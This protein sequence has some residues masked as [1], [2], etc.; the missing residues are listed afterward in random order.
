MPL[1]RDGHGQNTLAL[2]ESRLGGP[3]L[4]LQ[5]AQ[6]LGLRATGPQAVERSE[7]PKP[8]RGIEIGEEARSFWNFK[9]AIKANV[10]F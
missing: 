8:S 6:P 7:R 10:D 1:R 9:R 2:F 4:V 3:G 5:P